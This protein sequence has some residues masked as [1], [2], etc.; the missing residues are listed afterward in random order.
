MSTLTPEQLRERISE[1]IKNEL[2]L[3]YDLGQPLPADIRACNITMELSDGL[4][5]NTVTQFRFGIRFY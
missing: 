4:N 1:C 5:P 2:G 3:K